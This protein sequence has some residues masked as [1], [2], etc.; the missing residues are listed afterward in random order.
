MESLRL[1]GGAVV[2]V[3]VVVGLGDCCVCV[4]VCAV[5]GMRMVR[6]QGFSAQ[7]MYSGRLVQCG[8]ENGLLL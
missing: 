4:C 6:L 7:C 5:A 2:V 1:I 3:V 8:G